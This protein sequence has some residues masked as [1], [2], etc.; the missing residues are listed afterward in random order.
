MVK[1]MLKVFIVKEINVYV[2]WY[3]MRVRQM[4]RVSNIISFVQASYLKK[5]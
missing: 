4:E 1:H 3:I 5:K 2:Y